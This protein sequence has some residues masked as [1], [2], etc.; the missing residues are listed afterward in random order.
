MSKALVKRSSGGTGVVPAVCSALLPGLG[1]V[2]NGEADKGVGMMAVYVVA[3]ASVVGA[4]PFIGWVAGV[5][6]GATWVVSVADA[7]IQGKR[8]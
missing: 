8:K 7:Y 1:Q 6:A 3:G 2:V 5:F 4:I